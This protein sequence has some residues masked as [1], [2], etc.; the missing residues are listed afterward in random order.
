MAGKTTVYV[1]KYPRDPLMDVLVV[2]LEYGEW[3]MERQKTKEQQNKATT[4]DL[5]A[6]PS[7]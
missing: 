2:L 1:P 7:T 6:Q 4:P 5:Q 3:C